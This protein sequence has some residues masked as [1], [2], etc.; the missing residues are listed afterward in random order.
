MSVASYKELEARVNKGIKWLDKTQG[1]K[2]WIKSINISFFDISNGYQCVV[3]QVFGSY[4]ALMSGK[5]GIELSRRKSIEYG[6]YADCQ[7]EKSNQKTFDKLQTIWS[8]KLK[9]MK[10]K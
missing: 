2:N 3:G 6:F 4:C 7:N 5:L 10:A 9:R 1:R 8:A